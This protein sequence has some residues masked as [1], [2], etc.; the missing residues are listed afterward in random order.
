MGSSGVAIIAGLLLFFFK[1]STT[2][3]IPLYA[4]G[5]FTAFTCS[6]SGMFARHWRRREEGWR[7]SIVINGVGAVSTGSVLIVIMVSKFTIGAWIPIFVMP[8]IMLFCKVVHRHYERVDKALRAEPD[9]QPPRMQHNVV[10]LVPDI[11]KGVLRSLEFGKSLG[12]NHLTAVT[13]VGD[14]DQREAIERKWDEYDVDVPLAIIRSSYREL[15]RPV[16]RFL[17]DLERQREGETIIVIIP[18]FIV[19]KWWESLLHNQSTILLKGRLLFRKNTAV[20][21]LTTHLDNLAS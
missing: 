14:E 4:V 9:W 15:T 16:L 6:Q 5:V 21:S 17:D 10:V 19:E 13:V 8:L 20:T 2:A 1:G 18:E 7:R 12:P 11:H 3:L